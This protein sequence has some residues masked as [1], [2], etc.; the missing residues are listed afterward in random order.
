MPDFCW[1]MLVQWDAPE[2]CSPL[3]ARGLQ[4]RVHMRG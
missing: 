1:K 4:G 3:P 2:T